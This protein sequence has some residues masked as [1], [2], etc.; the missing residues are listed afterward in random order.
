[1]K[2]ES[3]DHPQAGFLEACLWEQV[4]PRLQYSQLIKIINRY[5]RD[6]GFYRQTTV[7]PELSKKIVDARRDIINIETTPYKAKFPPSCNCSALPLLD[8]A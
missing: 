5:Y 4:Y 6:D 1:M 2:G 8:Q 3:M 7:A